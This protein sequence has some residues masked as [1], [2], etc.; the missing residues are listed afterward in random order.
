MGYAFMS[1]PRRN[2][3]PIMEATF[4]TSWCTC[5]RRSMRQPRMFCRQMGTGTT[6][7]SVNSSDSTHERPVLSIRI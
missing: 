1:T 2:S 6:L 5:P 4:S 7:R 3:V